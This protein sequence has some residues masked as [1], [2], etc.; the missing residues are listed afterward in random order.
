LELAG[1]GGRERRSRATELLER[2]GLGDKLDAHPAQLSGGQRQR[3]GIARALAPR[4]RVLLC[5][6]ATSALDPV[7]TSSVLALLRTLTEIG[8]GP[9]SAVASACRGRRSCWSGWAWAT[10]STPTRP[11]S[12]GASGSGWASPVPWLPGRGCSCATR[13]PRRWTRSPPRRCWR[14][15]GPSP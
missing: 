13:P 9:A 12:P 14:C 7:S 3:V 2:V 8:G 15:C 6:E 10:S 5:D 11:S 1:V 4:P